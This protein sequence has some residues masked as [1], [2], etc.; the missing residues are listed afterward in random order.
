M[1]TTRI[2]F[3]LFAAL[4]SAVLAVPGRAAAQA[5]KLDDPTIIAIFDAANSWDMETGAL[6]AKKATTRELRDFGSMLVRDHRAVR[7][8]GRDLAKKLG[9]HPT[10][11]KDFAMAKGHAD[12]MR[13]LQSARGA[14]FDRAF[15]EHEVAY[16]KAVIDAVTT[17]LLPSLQNAEAKELVTKVAPA[18]KAHMD[19]AQYKLDRLPK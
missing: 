7:Q 6:A 16:H 8:Q 9:V 14:A 15:L 17:T 12:A 5:A 1:P 18:F 11:P 13:T 4:S 3:A 10:P 19:A 2:R